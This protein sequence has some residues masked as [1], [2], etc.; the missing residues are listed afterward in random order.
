MDQ[1]QK[2]D[3]Q[4]DD[5]EESKC[6]CYDQR[7]VIHGMPVKKQV[8]MGHRKESRLP[9]EARRGNKRVDEKALGEKNEEERVEALTEAATIDFARSS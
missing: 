5:L 1:M 6:Q 4:S 2:R 7:Q 9:S 3:E 8:A